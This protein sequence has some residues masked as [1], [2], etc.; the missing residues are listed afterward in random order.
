M[1][2][3][4]PF[5]L[6][7]YHE[8]REPPAVRASYHGAFRDALRGDT[9]E[10]YSPLFHENDVVHREAYPFEGKLLDAPDQLEPEEGRAVV[11]G[12]L[13]HGVP[14]R[15]DHRRHGFPWDHVLERLA[16]YG[17]EPVAPSLGHKPRRTVP[18]LLG[19]RGRQ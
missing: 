13:D 15:F 18:E 11:Q 14:L 6:V 19:I 2:D 9:L 16:N 7:Q 1:R 3:L 10:S 5:H 8:R 12:A 4:G 17:L